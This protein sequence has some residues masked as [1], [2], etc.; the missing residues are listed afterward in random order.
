MT[1]YT[2]GNAAKQ[3]IF[4]QLD[5][6]FGQQPFT[7]L[8]MGCGAMSTWP[9]FVASHPALSLRGIDTDVRAVEEGRK[10]FAG[11]AT[12]SLDV[13]DAQRPIMVTDADVVV[14][15]SAIEHVVDRPAFLRT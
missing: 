10:R 11:I 5:A 15:L 3:W 13:M 9:E 8:D 7:V 1:I 14:A 12:V 6:R 2:R 4:E